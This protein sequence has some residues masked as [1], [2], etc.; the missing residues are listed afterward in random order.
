M[1]HTEESLMALADDYGREIADCPNMPTTVERKICTKKIE[2]ARDTLRLA[3]REVLAE[4]DIH[5]DEA[6]AQRILRTQQRE[7]AEKAEAECDRLSKDA[8]RYRWLRDG[9]DNKGTPASWIA[10]NHY[11]KDWD[12]AIDAALKEQP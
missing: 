1:T 6:E 7:R 9:C 12:D 5:K 4:R 3:I 8:E 2:Q 10:H 11:G